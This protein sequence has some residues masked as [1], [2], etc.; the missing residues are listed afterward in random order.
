M[1]GNHVRQQSVERGGIDPHLVAETFTAGCVVRTEFTG[2]SDPFTQG[3][4]PFET[5][6][7]RGDEH[8]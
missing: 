7:R 4:T 3:D 5:L 8:G 1:L 6:A 2:N